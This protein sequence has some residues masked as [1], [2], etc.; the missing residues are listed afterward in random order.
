[1][2]QAA[3]AKRASPQRVGRAVCCEQKRLDERARIPP[4]PEEWPGSALSRAGA[5]PGPHYSVSPLRGLAH[6]VRNLGR[7]RVHLGRELDWRA[8]NCPVRED[9]APKLLD[10]ASGLAMQ[11][12][13][14]GLL[15][16]GVGTRPPL[17]WP[18][19]AASPRGRTSG[20]GRTRAGRRPSTE[21]GGHQSSSWAITWAAQAPSSTKP[22]ANSSNAP[23]SKRTAE[24][25]ATIGRSGGS[26]SER[27]IGSR[28]R[29]R[30]RRLGSSTL[31]RGI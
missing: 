26:P 7:A 1:M 13:G 8:W 22:P 15:S 2:P 27:T 3:R 17:P 25:K 18:P 11:S 23:P 31:G 21:R 20:R 14:K 30:M 5:V 28:A 6:R 10:S 19:A 29:K 16:A 24:P 9:A 4:E 12:Q